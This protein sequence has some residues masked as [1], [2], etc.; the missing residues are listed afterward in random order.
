VRTRAGG[1]QASPVDA[2][3]ASAREDP[4]QRFIGGFIAFDEAPPR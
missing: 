2:F 1:D 4:A 3:I